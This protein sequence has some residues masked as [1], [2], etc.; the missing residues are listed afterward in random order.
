MWRPDNWPEIA[1][2]ISRDI[3]SDVGLQGLD[4]EEF[5]VGG[6]VNSAIERSANAILEALKE[7]ALFWNC[8]G[9]RAGADS[10]VLK[11]GVPNE[12]GWLV[13]IPDVI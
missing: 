7:R 6:A 10:A 2:K 9:M 4:D 13:I 11:V 12:K 8:T 1:A 3:D 5:D